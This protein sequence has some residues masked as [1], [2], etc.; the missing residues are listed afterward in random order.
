MP[1]V[2]KVVCAVAPLASSN[3]PSLSRSQARAAIVPSASVEV[4]AS[5]IC[6]PATGAAGAAV[7]EAVGAWLAGGV[8]VPNG[9]ATR[10][11]R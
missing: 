7:K 1:A 9:L 10:R 4:S 6:W 2:A 8:T 11:T 5:W 3:W